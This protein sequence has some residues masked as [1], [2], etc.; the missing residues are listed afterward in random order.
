M[1]KKSASVSHTLPR[2]LQTSLGIPFPWF[3]QIHSA[4]LIENR[5]IVLQ[6]KG[7]NHALLGLKEQGK[8]LCDALPGVKQEQ[9]ND[10]IHNFLL[11]CVKLC[12]MYFIWWL[13]APDVQGLSR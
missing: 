6:L 9:P 3:Q 5:C 8:Y 10:Q 11:K 2:S 1:Q 12:H 4:S 13:S 7:K